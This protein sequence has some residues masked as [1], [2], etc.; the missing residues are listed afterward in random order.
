MH[1]HFMLILSVQYHDYPHFT[2]EE[3]D[4][5]RLSN[6]IE[7]TQLASGPIEVRQSRI[8]HVCCRQRSSGSGKSVHLFEISHP[9]Q[10]V[11]VMMDIYP[12]EGMGRKGTADLVLGHVDWSC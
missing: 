2:D 1:L 9:G 3:T 8:Y 7:T 5:N 6:V 12:A 11:T 10:R 4:T